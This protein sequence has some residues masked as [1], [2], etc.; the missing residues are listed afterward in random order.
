[1]ISSHTK[2][3]LNRNHHPIFYRWT[4]KNAV[5]PHDTTKVSTSDA[6]N[7]PIASQRAADHVSV[8]SDR[9][10]RA[11]PATAGIRQ[12]CRLQPLDLLEGLGQSQVGKLFETA[13]RIFKCIFML[14]EQETQRWSEF[15]ASP[16]NLTVIS[17]SETENMDCG[18][19]YTPK[20]ST[21]QMSCCRA[22]RIW[23]YL[24]GGTGIKWLH[25]G[26]LLI[27]HQSACPVNLEQ[28]AQLGCV[29]MGGKYSKNNHLN[30]V[31][32]FRVCG[33]ELPRVGSA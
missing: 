31:F 6:G 21:E 28:S 22:F 4:C 24:D 33:K 3:I 20:I 29:Q 18:Q 23:L 10:S 14:L 1:M 25:P 17:N 8:G 2:I 15:L 27:P 26:C 32:F 11:R 9:S 30:T 16:E 19:S 13:L 12:P 5:T 7:H